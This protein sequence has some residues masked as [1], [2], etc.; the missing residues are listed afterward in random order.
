MVM[1]A[2]PIVLQYETKTK[3]NKVERAQNE[4]FGFAFCLCVARRM[5]CLPP[6]LLRIILLLS[7]EFFSFLGEFN[8]L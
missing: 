2:M 4:M 6:L 3:I 5:R 7:L 1:V 8:K